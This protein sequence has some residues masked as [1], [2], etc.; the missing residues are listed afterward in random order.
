MQR[1]L[2][3]QKTPSINVIRQQRT[4][5]DTEEKETE[6]IYI[7]KQKQNQSR[8]QVCIHRVTSLART[9][10]RGSVLQKRVTYGV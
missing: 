6:T 9:Q 7:K 4:N 2:I 5:N 3:V 8:T 10:Q 1:S